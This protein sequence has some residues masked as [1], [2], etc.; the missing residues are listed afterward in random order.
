[1][2]RKTSF[3]CIHAIQTPNYRVEEYFEKDFQVMTYL[4]QMQF[5]TLEIAFIALCS[6][7]V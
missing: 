3:F 1:M 7:L 2:K 6:S 5:V 4:L